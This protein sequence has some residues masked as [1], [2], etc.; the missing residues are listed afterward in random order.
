VNGQKSKHCA[1]DL[2]FGG[3]ITWDGIRCVW[4]HRTV[5][6]SGGAECDLSANRKLRNSKPTPFV[7]PA[8]LNTLVQNH[9]LH[10]RGFRCEAEIYLM[11][12]CALIAMLVS[13]LVAFGQ[14]NE[15]GRCPSTQ[16]RIM[17][18]EERWVF[19]L[20]KIE[21]ES[22][23]VASYADVEVQN[24]GSK[25]IRDLFFLL[26]FQDGDGFHITIPFHAHS[27][28]VETRGKEPY[29]LWTSGDPIVEEIKPGAKQRISAGT[30]MRLATCPVQAKL[31]LVELQFGDGRTF[32]HSASWRMEATPIGLPVS[33]SSNPQI[34]TPPQLLAS[35]E[36]DSR[37]RVSLKKLEP[38]SNNLGTWLRQIVSG[39]SFHPSI[40]NGVSIA[41]SQKWLLRFHEQAEPQ[42]GLPSAYVVREGAFAVV[43]LYP[44]GTQEN[45]GQAFIRYGGFPY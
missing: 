14:Q 26:E 18:S 3:T 36:I 43:D 4:Q 17:P 35:V 12:R 24:I 27:T 41:S 11:R 22:D 8:G 42:S 34:P 19:S 40:Q 28:S 37:G 31:T 16:I 38:E 33:V 7:G 2:Q 32:K 45:H 44:F 20:P 23:D 13:G 15:D 9:P 39:W 5:S 6:R 1:N 25:P 29:D 10:V 21:F 30:L